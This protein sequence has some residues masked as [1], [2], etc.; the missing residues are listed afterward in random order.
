[1]TAHHQPDSA[2]GV[3]ERWAAHGATWRVL[4]LTDRLAV[5]ELCT[6]YG[7]SVDELWS[8]DPDVIRF[9]RGRKPPGCR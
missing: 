1:M 3:L 6:C 8:S 9:L 2:I 5:V 7:E 4:T